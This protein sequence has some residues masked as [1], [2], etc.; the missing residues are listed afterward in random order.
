M[1]TNFSKRNS[2][3]FTNLNNLTI[4]DNPKSTRPSSDLTISNLKSSKYLF[5]SGDLTT[6]SSLLKTKSQ[7][8]SLEDESYD[9]EEQGDECTYQVS[10]KKVY[11]NNI[12][13]LTDS[14][15][16]Q[17]NTGAS[18]NNGLVYTR[19]KIKQL[20]YA[21]LAKFIENLINSDTGEMDSNLVQT[22]LATYRTF[23]DTKTVLSKF[24]SRY[25]KVLPASLEMTEDVRQLYLKNLRLIFKMWL[26]NYSEDFDEPLDYPNL[27]ELY[28]I[29]QKYFPESG[30]INLIRKKFEIFRTNDQSSDSLENSQSSFNSNIHR[31]S[32][33]NINSSG[34]MENDFRVKLEDNFMSLESMYIAEQMTYLDKTYFQK[35]CPH[36]CLGAVWGTRYQ[37]NNVGKNKMTMSSN[38]NNSNSMLTPALSDKFAQ[39][40][41]F[42][43][44]F[45]LVSY[46]V[47]STILEKI[48]L[49]PAQRAKIIR[50]WIEIAQC[51]RQLKNFYSLNAIVQSLNTQCISRLE[52]T[53]S[54]VS[55]EA[56]H[57]IEQL[58]EIFSQD[59]NQQILRD[60]LMKE[61][62]SKYAEINVGINATLG[63][64]MKENLLRQQ[65]KQ[66]RMEPLG[67]I[68]FL[69][70]FLRDLE[71]LNAQSRKPDKNMINVQQ[72]RKEFEIIAQIKLLQQASQLYNIK[73]DPL[74]SKWLHSQNFLSEEDLYKYTYIIEPKN[75]PDRNSRVKSN[76]SNRSDSNESLNA[77]NLLLLNNNLKT[78]NIRPK[79]LI[80]NKANSNHSRCSSIGS[81][82][83]INSSES[84][85][86]L[87][88]NSMSNSSQNDSCNTSNSLDFAPRNQINQYT[89]KVK[90]DQDEPGQ[91]ESEILYKKMAINDRDRTNGVKKKILEKFLLNSDNI[92][93]YVLVQ[94][95]DNNL[96]S[97]Q[98]EI[99]IDDNINV[100]YALKCVEDIQLVL[101]K[102]N[103]TNMN[104]SNDSGYSNNSNRLSHLP[105]QCPVFASGLKNGEIKLW[106]FDTGSLVYSL[107]KHLSSVW[108]LEYLLNNYLASG[109]AN[110]KIIIWNLTNKTIHAE[111]IHNGTV[112]SIISVD[113]T[114]FAS[115][116]FNSIKL[117]WIE[118]FTN[119]LIIENA[120]LSDIIGLRYFSNR[121]FS[122]SSDGILK[123]WKNFTFHF[124][125]NV[126]CTVLSFEITLDGILLC[127]CSDG[128]IK[129]Y[130]TNS[131]YFYLFDTLYQ[132]SSITSLRALELG[133]F[134]SGSSNGLLSLWNYNTSTIE[135]IILGHPSSVLALEYTGKN[136][137]LSGPLRAMIRSW[138]IDCAKRINHY[139][140]L[141][142]VYSLKYLN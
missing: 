30:L 87:L 115:A 109:D 18:S 20:R 8:N 4:S 16:N 123:A 54:E 81:S 46:F 39:F 74:F 107:N 105:P 1:L 59:G 12:N 116:S 7:I 11:N 60:I 65:K 43:E 25:A 31:R 120:H 52:K 27:N 56:K 32:L 95:F 41:P 142:A 62:T 70:M 28:R 129:L 118:S 61:G 51:C 26:E 133:F 110:G 126:N 128:Y 73:P 68:P 48:D 64:K 66:Q 106:D 21:S 93:D 91:R 22:F 69:G 108:S 103:R 38:S 57:Q 23:S 15:N 122:I 24:K 94:I 83:L 92:E 96:N 36:K 80:N 58:T 40:T 139:N 140:A 71:Y 82:D 117:W 29:A 131:N 99:Q 97:I 135:W 121:L 53:W 45:N 111:L 47:Q 55:N 124:E 132:N 5:K 89:V 76:L 100:F 63:R 42:I 9:F 112:K 14:N 90:I 79:S 104:S 86:S 75:E 3:S 138:G 13:H 114:T 84:P 67:T 17:I 113:L 6:Q 85:K 134:V 101:R 78:P 49:K 44:Q 98:Q 136:T 2:T 37:K 34:E 130:S 19:V 125:T 88:K 137:F 77:T 10:F 102:R 127:G 33:S 72:K 50:K 119:R 141:F 35:I